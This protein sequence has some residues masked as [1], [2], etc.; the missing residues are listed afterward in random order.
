MRGYSFEFVTKIRSLAKSKSAPIG[1]R[2]G[3]QAVESG[4]SIRTVADKLGVSRM[5]VYDWFT[6]KYQPSPKYLKKLT[7]AVSGK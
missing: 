5:T 2:L 7:A 6:G 4:V 3:L 1:V